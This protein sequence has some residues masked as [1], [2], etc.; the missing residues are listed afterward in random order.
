M[1]SPPTF[2]FSLLW[3]RKRSRHPQNNVW[4]Y[5]SYCNAYQRV[6]HTRSTP[7]AVQHQNQSSVKIRDLRT[8]SHNCLLLLQSFTATSLLSLLA[9]GISFLFL[10]DRESLSQ[11]FISST[12]CAATV[13]EAQHLCDCPAST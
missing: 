3:K 8:G 2:P 1:A 12:G 10:W 13:W 11:Y 5:R 4:K 7:T 6:N 9:G